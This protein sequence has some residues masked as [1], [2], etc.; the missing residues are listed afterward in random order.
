VAV[1]RINVNS[2]DRVTVWLEGEW[3]C[4]CSYCG[5]C[6]RSR[7]GTFDVESGVGGVYPHVLEV[8]VGNNEEKSTQKKLLVHGY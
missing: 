7:C 1:D 8:A 4:W 6:Q 3:S 5:A 2:P